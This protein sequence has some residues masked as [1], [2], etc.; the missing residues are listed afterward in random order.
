MSWD[1]KLLILKK[2]SYLN[3]IC[4]NIAIAFGGRT[5]DEI[6]HNQQGGHLL[7]SKAVD[8]DEGGVASG[9]AVVDSPYLI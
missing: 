3:D 7:R 6:Y 1:L 4:I 5:K 2:H 8:T 9:F